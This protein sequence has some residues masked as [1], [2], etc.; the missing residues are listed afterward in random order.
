M[1][2]NHDVHFFTL[3]C[4]RARFLVPS[5]RH[6]V[7]FFSEDKALAKAQKDSNFSAP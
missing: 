1:R 3:N 5:S 2:K 4:V 7:G 6:I